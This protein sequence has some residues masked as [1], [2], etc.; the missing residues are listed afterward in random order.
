ME[1]QDRQQAGDDSDAMTRR[2]AL[3]VIGGVGL[4]LG[5]VGMAASVGVAEAST[6]SDGAAPA[7]PTGSPSEA[8][9]CVLTTEIDDGP[10]YLDLEKVRHDISEDRPGVP[11]NLRFVVV[12]ATTCRPLPKAAVDIWMCDATGTYSG[13]ATPSPADSGPPPGGGFPHQEPI[14]DKTFLRGVQ[15]TDA[16]GVASFRSIFPGWY[17]GRAIHIHVKVHIGG[18]VTG[19]EYHGGSVSYTGQVFFPE[20]IITEVE[21]LQPYAANPIARVLNSAD[22]VYNRFDGASTLISLAHDRRGSVRDGLSGSVTLGVNPVAGS[23][24]G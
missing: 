10:Y 23:T 19:S 11:V 6:A 16:R 13:Y 18:T 24:A 1:D 2:G 21:K 3:R 20:S 15:L 22:G 4:G 9:S 12:D 14:N 8:P 17:T 5:V 7:R